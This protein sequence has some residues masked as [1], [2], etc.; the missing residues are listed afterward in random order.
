MSN[1]KGF[2][3]LLILLPATCLAAAA[4]PAPEQNPASS[5]SSPAQAT[6]PAAEADNTC[7]GLSQLTAMNWYH[8][9]MCAD[10][11]NKL[12][13]REKAIKDEIAR[14]YPAFHTALTTP[15]LSDVGKYLATGLPYLPDSDPTLTEKGCETNFTFLNLLLKEGQ[16]K[17]AILQCWEKPRPVAQEHLPLPGNT[18]PTVSA[19]SG[20]SCRVAC[21]AHLQPQ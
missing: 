9:T 8:A 13:Q 2:I 7:R 21:R 1:M 20:P 10:R 18:Q 19:C 5:V 16:W 3:S 11:H 17:Q 4:Q 12:K 15:P 6:P 14:T